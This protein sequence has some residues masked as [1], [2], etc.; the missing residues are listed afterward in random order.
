[1]AE[2]K[3][4]VS[5]MKYLAA[6]SLACLLFIVG[7]FFGSQITQSKVND[8]L[9]TE[10][11]TRLQLENLD[12]EGMLLQDAPCQ[13]PKL[14]TE[15]LETLGTKL[16]Y[17]ESEY[18]KDDPRILEL[19]KPYTLL[20]LRHYLSLKSMVEKCNQNFTFV[21]FFYSNEPSKMDQ[22]EKEGFVLDYLKKKHENINIYAFD[23]NLD[24]P[25]L[26]V[27]KSKYNVVDT[28]TVVIDDQV[29]VGFHDKDEMESVLVRSF[30]K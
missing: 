15:D 9:A 1:M 16:T 28:P 30:S 29:Y 17:L 13:S 8:I 4:E 22:S 18:S 11:Q 3:R 21:L 2:K 19:K 24:V 12:I 26:N 7:I 25:V 20:E 14:L 23:V 5:K 10:Q 6:F 27:L